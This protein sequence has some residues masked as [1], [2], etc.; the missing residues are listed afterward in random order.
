MQIDVVLK[1]L[2]APEVK[3]EGPS[4][5]DV[6]DEVVFYVNGTD[7]DGSIEMFYWSTDKMGCSGLSET[8]DSF[9]GN[10]ESY[11]KLARIR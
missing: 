11:Q 7:R 10:V 8:A 2:Y 4:E 6:N 3:I 5:V 9:A 1:N